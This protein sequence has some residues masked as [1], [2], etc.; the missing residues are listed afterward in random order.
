MFERHKLKNISVLKE[1][2]YPYLEL[3]YKKNNLA[4]R[5]AQENFWKQLNAGSDRIQ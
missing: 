4:T 1:K 5:T 2:Y 3:Y